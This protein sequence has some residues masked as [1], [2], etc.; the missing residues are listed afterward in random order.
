MGFP[1]FTIVGDNCRE[2]LVARAYVRA[3]RTS[4]VRAWRKRSRTART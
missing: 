3:P 1:A 2:P 4:G